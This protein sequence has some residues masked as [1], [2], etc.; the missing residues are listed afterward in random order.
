VAHP[1]PS[2]GHHPSSMLSCPECGHHWDSRAAIGQVIRC[3]RCRVGRTRV[4]VLRLVTASNGPPPDRG[5]A[6]PPVDPPPPA[7]PPLPATPCP[8]CH[9]PRT[10]STRSTLARCPACNR[11]Q[12]P[13]AVLATAVERVVRAKAVAVREDPE[14]INRQRR[15]FAGE[16]AAVIEACRA[17]RLL[18]WMAALLDHLDNPAARSLVAGAIA[19]CQDALQT[20]QEAAD[21]GEL[22]VALRGWQ[23]CSGQLGAQAN[24]IAGTARFPLLNEAGTGEPVSGPHEQAMR[25][26]MNRVIEADDGNDYDPD[27]GGADD[28]GDGP[29]GDSFAVKMARAW[30]VNA[31]T[32]AS[33]G[34]RGAPALPPIRSSGRAIPSR[35]T[36]V[37][38]TAGDRGGVRYRPPGPAYAQPGMDS[39][40][41]FLPG[42]VVVVQPPPVATTPLFRRSW[43]RRKAAQ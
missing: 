7:I 4:P 27:D 24:A 5:P 11:R 14:Q 10:R 21:Y 26:A 31:T 12:L 39:A 2:R 37:A 17:D 29:D 32:G 19:T 6:D 13:D 38:L 42:T 16:R 15:E 1:T 40:R 35:P 23:E 22:Q 28:D 36:Q 25:P 43:L 20:M 33:V 9:G 30:R 41:R 8:D 3:P 18:N 34:I